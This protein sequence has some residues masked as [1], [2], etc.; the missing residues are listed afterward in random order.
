MELLRAE[1]SLATLAA[2]LEGIASTDVRANELV[3]RCT[4]GR[5]CLQEL[6]DLLQ[7]NNVP[8][9]RIYCEPP[10]LNDVFL[11][12]TGKELRD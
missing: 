11:E 3:V 2:S 12:I 4:A 9:G 6:M 8:Y 10:T 1:G 5:N 7:T